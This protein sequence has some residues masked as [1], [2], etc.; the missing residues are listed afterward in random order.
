MYIVHIRFYLHFSGT[1]FFS[2]PRAVLFTVW[3]YESL[4][5]YIGQVGRKVLVEE[6]LFPEKIKGF[7]PQ[8]FLKYL[9]TKFGC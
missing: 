5:V 8:P 2:H 6:A 1:F 7:W 3:V 9:V 4:K